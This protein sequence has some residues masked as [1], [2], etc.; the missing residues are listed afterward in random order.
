MIMPPPFVHGTNKPGGP[1]EHFTTWQIV[2]IVAGLVLFVGVVF[3]AGWAIDQGL[4]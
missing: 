1:D 3:L 4:I 2:A